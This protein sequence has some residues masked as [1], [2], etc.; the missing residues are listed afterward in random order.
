MYS[1][2]VQC[3]YITFYNKKN[4]EKMKRFLLP[5]KTKIINKYKKD[6]GKKKQKSKEK[7]QSYF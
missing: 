1:F 5:I 2:M 3:L 6:I 7:R 4:A